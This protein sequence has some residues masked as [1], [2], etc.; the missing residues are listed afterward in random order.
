MF[1]AAA[2]PM[3]QHHLGESVTVRDVDTNTSVAITAVKGKEM[4]GALD[5][6]TEVM[7]TG[8]VRADLGFE[9]AE[10]DELTDADG[11]VW[12]CMKPSE[13]AHGTYDV[14]AWRPAENT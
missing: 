3:L 12:R 8:I 4:L 14:Q 5:A 11:V 6:K 1:Q 2:L 9:L 7:F 10:D 13:T